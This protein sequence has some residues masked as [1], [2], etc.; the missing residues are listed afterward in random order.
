MNPATDAPS[1]VVHTRDDELDLIQDPPTC[2][3]SSTQK[4]ESPDSIVRENKRMVDHVLMKG[5]PKLLSL[6]RSKSVDGLEHKKRFK[7]KATTN[8]FSADTEGM[9]LELERS[10]A[11]SKRT[12]DMATA[13]KLTAEKTLVDA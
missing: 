9:F 12:V 8:L 11:K 7:S 13:A 2:G 3:S 6:T 5:S 10:E 4:T 1:Q